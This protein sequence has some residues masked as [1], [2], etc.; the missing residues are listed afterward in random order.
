MSFTLVWLEESAGT[1]HELQMTAL[2]S[3]KN[4]QTSK[5]AKASKQ[6]GLFKQVLKCIEW[7]QA[8]PRYPGLKTHKYDSIDNPYDPDA[9]VFEAYVQNRAP[10]AYRVFWCYGPRKGEITIIAITPHT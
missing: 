9:K 8:N 5:K 2:K 6:E 7:L 4:R 3:L 1:F 10:G